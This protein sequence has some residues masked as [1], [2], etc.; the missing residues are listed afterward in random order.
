[1][2]FLHLRNRLQTL[3]R[4]NRHFSILS[5]NSTTP[6]SSKEKTRA[7]LSLLK[8]ETNP[9][10]IIEI[11]REASLIPETHLDRI[12]F[13]M[14]ISKLSQSNN[15]SYIKQFIDEL[16]T[17]PD[18]Q[19]SEKFAAHAIILYGQ[20][21]M[22][23]DSIRV[24]EEF[25]ASCHD[26]GGLGSGSG[27]VK[28]LNALLFAFILAKKFT[29]VNRVFLEF[30]KRFNIEPDLITY[31]TVVKAFAESGSSDSCYS[32][33]AEMDRKGV[34]PNSTTFQN[35][36]EGFYKEEKEV[37]VGKVL[38]MMKEKYKI[39]QNVAMF[40]IRIRS[41]CKLKRPVEA[42]AIYD[43]MLSRKR[44]PN[45]GTFSNLILGFC[46]EGNLEEAQKLFRSMLSRG[47]K[48]ESECYFSLVHYLCEGE[49]FETALR[50]CQESMEKG[51]VPN[52]GTMKTLVNGLAR[53]G[54]VE[55]AKELV[56]KMKEKFPR[57]V[58]QWEEVEAGLPQ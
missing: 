44:K 42:K 46:V 58:N 4:S 9:E 28:T 17:R 3:I 33:L 57:N 50:F 29:E 40:N 51:W 30:P 38:E 6:L 31:N 2:A 12:V 21:A 49:D 56:G 10:K 53:I 27:S 7:A 35:M 32:V 8:F 24:F 45:A 14:A 13:S 1:M 52:Y 43:E 25:H 11:C 5:P 37:D 22:T 41:L 39:W 48:P 36:V 15:F 19:S 47:L 20:A 16:S 23:D 34:R 18:L 54:K 26:A 55:E